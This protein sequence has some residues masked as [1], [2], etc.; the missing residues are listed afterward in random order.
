[1]LQGVCTIAVSEC[2][3]QHLMQVYHYPENKIHVIHRGA[4]LKRFNPERMTQSEVILFAQKK[5]IPLDRPVIT[6]VGRLSKI[7]GQDLLLRALSHMKH[8][9]LTCLLVGGKA[10]PEYE[11]LLKEEIRKLPDTITVKTLSV[12]AQEIPMIYA[13]SD[14]VVSASVIPETF[15]RTVSEANAMNRIVIAFNHGGPTEIIQNGKT[16]FLVPVGDILTLAKQLD[17]VLDMTSGQR[18][19][20]QDA[21]RKRTEAF[22]SI[23]K[24]CE[25]TLELYKEVLQ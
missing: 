9:E 23:D 3:K 19:K 2:V 5:Q 14:V 22:F 8:Q 15:G 13:L 18:K 10:K 11:N 25:K 6:L 20:M 4:D 7:K 1:M 24:M 17:I 16:G 21:A 12:P